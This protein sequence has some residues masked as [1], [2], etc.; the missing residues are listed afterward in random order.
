MR[1]T[2]GWHDSTPRD[3]AR[4]PVASRGLVRLLDL[5]FPPRCGGCGREGTGWCARCAASVEPVPVTTLNGTPLVA[6]GRLDGP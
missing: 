4:R 5:I 6:A 2:P 1:R 3:Q